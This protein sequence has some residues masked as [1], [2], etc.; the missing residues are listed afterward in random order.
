M[1]EDGVRRVGHRPKFYRDPVHGQIRYDSTDIETAKPPRDAQRL[2]GWLL[3][4]LIDTPEFQRLRH[5]RQNGLAN[6]VFHGAEHSRFSHSMGVAHLAAEMHD[7]IVR[8][9]GETADN[10]RRSLQPSL[11][12]SLWRMCLLCGEETPS[13]GRQPKGLAKGRARLFWPG[14]GGACPALPLLHGP[15]RHTALAS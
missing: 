2:H 10:E 8:N 5:I 13:A 1:A 15:L 11:A 6:L 4:R 7:R 9:M 14:S 3:R 12:F